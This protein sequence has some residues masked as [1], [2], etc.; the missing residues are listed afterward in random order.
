VE[1]GSPRTAR[2]IVINAGSAMT[3]MGT[4]S[5]DAYIVFQFDKNATDDEKFAQLETY[6][7]ELRT[8]LRAGRLCY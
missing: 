4:L 7:R 1:P 2:G 6:V 3:S 8:I 5:A